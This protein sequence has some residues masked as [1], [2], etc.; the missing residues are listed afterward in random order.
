MLWTV[1]ARMMTR[2]GIFSSKGFKINVLIILDLKSRHS[3]TRNTKN[4]LSSSKSMGSVQVPRQARIDARQEPIHAY[5]S[6]IL[7]QEAP[8]RLHEISK[9]QQFTPVA[10]Q[11]KCHKRLLDIAQWVGRA[12]AAVDKEIDEMDDA[13]ISLWLDE[14]DLRR[15]LEKWISART[16]TTDCDDRWSPWIQRVQ[17]GG[18]NHKLLPHRIDVVRPHGPLRILP[19]LAAVFDFFW[20]F[21]NL[22]RRRSRE[23]RK[24]FANTAQLGRCP[25]HV[26]WKSTLSPR[27]TSS[28]PLR[29]PLMERQWRC[30]PMQRSPWKWIERVPQARELEVVWSIFIRQQN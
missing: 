12:A 21:S 18:G 8:E 4:R 5:W 25:S 6:A 17:D 23:G 26:W 7:H 19:R 14:Q 28:L 2:F 11:R 3:S 16:A 22:P 27:S 29:S 13:G 9:S 24:S 30:E 10:V 20:N 1:R 15:K